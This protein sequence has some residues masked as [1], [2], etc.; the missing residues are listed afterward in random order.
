MSR[1]I[2]IR[3]YLDLC[4]NLYQPEGFEGRFIEWLKLVSYFDSSYIN[5][6]PDIKQLRFGLR[7]F[8]HFIFN[9]DPQVRKLFFRLL[10]KTWQINPRLIKRFFTVITQYSHFYNFVKN[11]PEG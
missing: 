4:R 10:K 2:L 8:L 3:L 6:K 5:K 7:I 1:Q 11:M 9:E